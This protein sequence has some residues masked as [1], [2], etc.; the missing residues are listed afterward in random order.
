[1]PE[2]VGEVRDKTDA[3]VMMLSVGFLATKLQLA[4]K[5]PDLVERADRLGQA[6]SRIMVD[7]CADEAEVVEMMQQM[8]DLSQ[9]LVM[10][11]MKEESNASQAS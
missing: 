2:T 11:V 1:M 5:H 8:L 7:L 10:P 6:Y 4:Q 9:V 3:M